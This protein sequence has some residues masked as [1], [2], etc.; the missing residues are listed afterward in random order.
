MATCD[1]LAYSLHRPTRGSWT[2]WVWWDDMIVVGYSSVSLLLILILLVMEQYLS[3]H[4]I[5]SR[6][7]NY[8]NSMQASSSDIYSRL[9][10][11]GNIIIIN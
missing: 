3:H 9:D 2:C 11:M 10:Q 5:C 8:K 1:L 4:C 6:L 7:V